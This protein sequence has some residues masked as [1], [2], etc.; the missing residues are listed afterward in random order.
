M[1]ADSRDARRTEAGMA[2]DET[3]R[4]KIVL[5]QALD[6]W[7]RAYI[8]IQMK[9]ISAQPGDP[10]APERAL[11]GAKTAIEAWKRGRAVIA[12]LESKIGQS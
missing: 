5:Y 4:L 7:L 12:K 8:V 9:N 10:S 3:E 1:V 2:G 6:E 11:F